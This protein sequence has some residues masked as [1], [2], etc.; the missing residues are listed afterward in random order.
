MVKHI[1]GNYAYTGRI[2]GFLRLF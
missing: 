1:Q 2:T